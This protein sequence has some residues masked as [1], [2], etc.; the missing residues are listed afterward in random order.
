[1]GDNVCIYEMRGQLAVLITRTL[2]A[3]PNELEFSILFFTS[4]GPTFAKV[5]NNFFYRRFSSRILAWGF[6][7]YEYGSWIYPRWFRS[8]DS[9]QWVLLLRL[10][11]AMFSN[12][13]LLKVVQC[14]GRDKVK[15]QIVSDQV[16]LKCFLDVCH[17]PWMSRTFSFRRILH[18]LTWILHDSV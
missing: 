5:L 7:F 6:W 10:S 14:Q 15:S 17:R 16:F 8:P 3:T 13:R 12:W 9:R 2:F 1:M 11:I 18:S 4:R